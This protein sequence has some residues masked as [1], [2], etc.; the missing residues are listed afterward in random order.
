MAVITYSNQ[1]RYNKRGPLDSKALVKTY[2][3][4][5]DQNTWLIDNTMAAYNGMLTAVW[6]NKEDTSKNGIYFLFDPTATSAVKVPD[7]T[8]EANWHKLAEMSDLTDFVQNLSALE[9][10]VAALEEDSDVVTYGYR[11]GFPTVG[12]ADKLYIAADEGKS[13]I[14]F[15][16]EYLPVGGNNYEEPEIIFGGSAD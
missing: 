4:L 7:V 10:R 9:A 3:N 2:T 13:Y 5:L 12:V 14:W 15:N 8:N 1:Y 16:D 11:S 6:M